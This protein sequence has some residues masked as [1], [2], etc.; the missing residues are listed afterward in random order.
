MSVK[1]NLLEAVF[2]LLLA[3]GSVAGSWAWGN[4]GVMSTAMSRNLRPAAGLAPPGIALQ[5][6]VSWSSVK[7]WDVAEEG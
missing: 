7:L 6:F 4:Q 3:E 5:G 2:L 1:G